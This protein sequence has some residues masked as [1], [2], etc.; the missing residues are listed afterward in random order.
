MRSFVLRHGVLVGIALLAVGTSVYFI[1]DI[2][3]RDPL[4]GLT[5]ATVE[6]GVVE[7][8][9]SVS[10][11][12]RSRN[13]AE[14]A[15][16][17]T[18]IVAAVP[19]IEGDVVEAGTILATLGSSREVANLQ[20]AEAELAIAEA[21]LQELRS[22]TR[23]EARAVTSASVAAAREEVERARAAGDLDVAN[24]TRAL[25][26]NNLVARST[27][28][29]E[30][31][32]APIISGTYR[33][34]TPGTYTLSVYSSGSN[35]GFSMRLSGLESGTYPVGVD[36]ATTFGTC[37]LFAQFAPD[38]TYHNSIWTIEIPNT[39]SVSYINLKNALADAKSTKDN[40]VAAAE[41]AL[42]LAE[43]RQSLENAS[44]LS[45]EIR[46]AEARVAQ[47]RASLTELT[48]TLADRSIVAPFAG[49]VTT[50]DILPGETAP[51]T[52]V[53][54][55]LATDAFEVIARIPEID[56]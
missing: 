45:T 7:T 1:V 40:S 39:T 47:A 53:I 36:Q 55:L 23:A 31:A 20:K 15:F 19:V 18:G 50:V 22:G 13:T 41:E 29:S 27:N 14:L 46:T 30:A 4:E 28:L 49:T 17:S 56:I 42:T 12:T 2:I 37:G 38:E 3:T 6:E 54:T 51:L 8:I 9:V 11:I 21:A 34:D 43:R 35:S 33:C 10:G 26:S 52:P 48:A 44:P 32:P 24:A 5:L 16:P 25:Y